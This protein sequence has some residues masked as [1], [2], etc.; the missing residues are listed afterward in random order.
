MNATIVHIPK[1][2]FSDDWSQN[3]INF[4]PQGTYSVANYAI[5][6][7]HRVEVINA[8]V[9]GNKDSALKRIFAAIDANESKVVGIPLH[10]HFSGADVMAAANEIKAHYGDIKIILGGI[11]ASIFGQ[12]LMQE[13][14]SLHGVVHGDGEVAFCRY[15]DEVDKGRSADFSTVPNLRWRTDNGITFNSIRF[16]A[17]KEEYSNYDYRIS[18]TVEDLVQYPN[19]LTMVDVVAGKTCDMT[20][21]KVGDK[22][23]FV[24]IGRGCS[25]NCVYCGGCR[26]SFKTHFLRP[27]PMARSS[28]SVVATIKDAYQLGFRKFHFCWD[29]EIKDRQSHIMGIFQ[30][31]SSKVSSDITIAYEFYKLPTPDFVE[32]C[33]RLFKQTILILSPNFFDY[34]TMHRYMGYSYTISELESTLATIERFD[35]CLPFVYFGI[36]PLE[37]WNDAGLDSKLDIIKRL[38]TGS[39]AKVSTMPIYAE[40]GS[41]WVH[42]QGIFKGHRFDFSFNDFLQEWK[43]PL[44]PWNSNLSGLQNISQIVDRINEAS[45]IDKLNET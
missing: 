42:F 22:I 39:K 4:L 30:E 1:G 5:D 43:K 9:F 19:G 23:F 41:P 21:E 33:S 15:L 40:P 3:Y 38:K 14:P 6:N 29:C 18:R 32:N 13:C 28:A 10:W 31:V 35:N 44:S 20:Q 2:F 25:Y 8:A 26:T 37:E 12:E 17:T 16:V 11:T 36:T 7:G 24:N 45:E 27:G 34:E